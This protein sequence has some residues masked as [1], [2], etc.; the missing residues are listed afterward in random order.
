MTTNGSKPPV[1]RFKE[2]RIKYREEHRE[3]WVKIRA[4]E[5]PL[6]EDSEFVMRMVID[7]DLKDVETGEPIPV[8]ERMELTTVQHAQVIAAWNDWSD[9]ADDEVKK[10]LKRDENSSSTSTD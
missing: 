1:I 7:W 2:I 9:R 6:S 8:G 5:K 10:T 4:G 3:I